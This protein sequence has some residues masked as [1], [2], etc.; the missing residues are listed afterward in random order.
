MSQ[1]SGGD[2]IDEILK[3]HEEIKRLFSDVETAG[4]ERKT[5]AFETLMRKLVVH[6]TAEQEIVHPILR[7]DAPEIR[8]QRLAEEKEGEKALAELYRMGTDDPSFD[9]A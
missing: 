3:D 2:L 9:A 1:Q 7:E 6:E 5:K 4:G 8:N